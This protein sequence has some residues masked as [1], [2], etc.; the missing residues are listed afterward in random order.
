MEGH[1]SRRRH[2]LYPLPDSMIRMRGDLLPRVP[3][4]TDPTEAKI[5]SESI[6]EPQPEAGITT[7]GSGSIS[8]ERPLAAGP[9]ET[10]S[11]EADAEPLKRGGLHYSGK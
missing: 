1:P 10:T 3:P 4:G 8:P 5:Q 2:I 9:A 6:T 7:P 11:W